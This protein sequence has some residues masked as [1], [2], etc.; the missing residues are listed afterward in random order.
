MSYVI[1]VFKN[2]NQNT[3]FDFPLPIY[4]FA[5]RKFCDALHFNSFYVFSW[6]EVTMK[7]NNLGQ[8]LHWHKN[9]VRWITIGQ[10]D[11]NNSFEKSIGT[12]K[13][14]KQTNEDCCF[15]SPPGS[16]YGTQAKKLAQIIREKWS[17]HCTKLL[18][19]VRKL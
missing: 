18:Y 11:N 13:V 16:I 3:I 2:Q 19:N 15:V 17:H 14:N 9:S 10:H 5:V 4:C 6:V 1:M 7:K 8:C 12:A